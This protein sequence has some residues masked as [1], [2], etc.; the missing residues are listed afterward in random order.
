MILKT[1]Q[2]NISIKFKINILTTPIFSSHNSNSL[3][4]S[5]KISSDNLLIILY[6]AHT[7]YINVTLKEYPYLFLFNNDRHNDRY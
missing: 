1:N 2:T 5:F 3:G 6:D 4:D 7:S